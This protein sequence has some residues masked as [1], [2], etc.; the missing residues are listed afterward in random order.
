MVDCPI[1]IDR[2]YDVNKSFVKYVVQQYQR[3]IFDN[4]LADQN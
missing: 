2:K 1:N 3:N 4:L